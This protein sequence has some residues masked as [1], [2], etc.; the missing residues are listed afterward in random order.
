MRK[1]LYTGI[2]LSLTLMSCDKDF[3]DVRE[4]DTSDNNI[5]KAEV[6]TLQS[7]VR[8]EKRGTDYF[9]EGDLKLSSEQFR[10]LDETG[11]IFEENARVLAPTDPF[12]PSTGIPLSSLGNEPHFSVKSV[13]INPTAY[14][15]W[16]MLR[17]TL[18]PSLTL[19]RLNII[20]DAITHW[21]ANTN[22][23]FYN[24]TGEPTVDPVYGFAYPYVEF[25][26]GSGNSSYVGRIGGRQEL[27]LASFQ[28]VRAA[29][30]EIGHAIGLLH[31]HN[32]PD[33][34][35]YI[36]IIT[37]NIKPGALHNFDK[38]TTN[39]YMIGMI[40]YTSVMMYGSRI[41]DS[42]MVYDITMNTLVKK[43][44]SPWTA[45]SSLSANDRAWANSFYLPYKARLDTYRELDDIVYKPDNTIMTPSERLSLQAALN[46]GNPYPPN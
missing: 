34:D 23:R 19:D 16:S 25:V 37:S 14:N 11:T 44:Y 31:E 3:D 33:R 36:N 18:H 6:I 17:Y 28:G 43:D 24:A 42:D 10:F 9:W 45:S 38:R 39:Y 4:V 12:H 20:Q 2:A 26:N 1:I 21:E 32:R 22:V 30:H 5:P 46:N 7:G 35:T 29:I 8:V 13:G 27:T 41:T 40:D 15:M